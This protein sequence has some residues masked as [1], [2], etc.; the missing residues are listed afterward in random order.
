VRYLKLSITLLLS[1]TVLFTSCARQS[2]DFILPVEQ[3]VGTTYADS[4]QVTTSPETQI[5]S[6]EE[7]TSDPYE[8]VEVE[9]PEADPYI[10]VSKIEFYANYTPA[11]DYWDAYYRSQHGFMSGSLDK[12][13]QN[14]SI[15]E[16]RP[17]ENGMFLK[18][19]SDLY[20]YDGHAYTVLDSKGDIAFT[21]YEGGGYVTLEE[22]AAYVFA[23]GDI[24][25]NYTSAKKGSPS[26]SPWGEY[27]R[28]NHSVFSGSTTKYPYE[29]ALPFI[30]G[31]GGPLSYYEIDIGT[32][33]TDCDPSY[34]AYHYNDGSRITRGA[35]RIVYSRFDAN[36]NKIIDVNE[37]FVFYTNNH[38]NDFRE[39]LNYEGGWGEIFGNITGGGSISSKSNYNPTPYVAVLNRDFRNQ[40]INSVSVVLPYIQI[41]CDKSKY[42]FN[43]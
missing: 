34:V 3:S 31:C 43:Y 28:L 35:A 24:P 25:A 6:E 20:S 36:H 39:Y 26:S 21:V 18:N 17:M 41:I 14:P 12:Q 29:P 42:S 10:T 38:Y 19:T 16:S 23:F 5:E 27:L 13:D 2:P 15:A 8:I 11:T 33:G 32:T 9:K 4:D 22:V 40:S 37:K 30:S 7:T 1:L